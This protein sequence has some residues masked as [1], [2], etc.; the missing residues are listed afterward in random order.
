MIETS[1]LETLKACLDGGGYAVCSMGPGYWTKSGHFICVWKYDDKYIYAND[2]ASSSRKKQKISD[3]VKQ[4]KRYFC[5][6][7]SIRACVY[8]ISRDFG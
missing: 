1:S 8:R 6:W 4:R 2:P 3:F 5:W 7:A